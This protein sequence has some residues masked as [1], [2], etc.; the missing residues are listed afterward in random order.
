MTWILKNIRK[1]T[2]S[3]SRRL[4]GREV[5]MSGLPRPSR[6]WKPS[7]LKGLLFGNR[8]VIITHNEC[9]LRTCQTGKHSYIVLQITVPHNLPEFPSAT[10]EKLDVARYACVFLLCR[11]KIHSALLAQLIFV[12]CTSFATCS[13]TQ[14]LRD[15]RIPPYIPLSASRIWTGKCLCWDLFLYFAVTLNC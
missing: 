13:W 10:S 11:M 7:V 3:R 4:C 2:A 8:T 9:K 1:S 12:C 14:S 15:L 6:R 5:W